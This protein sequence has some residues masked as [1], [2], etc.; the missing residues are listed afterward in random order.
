MG[1]DLRMASRV[2]RDIHSTTEGTLTPDD[3]NLGRIQGADPLWAAT[4][5]YWRR[6]S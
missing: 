3:F 2:S 1:L 6:E 4:G 5:V